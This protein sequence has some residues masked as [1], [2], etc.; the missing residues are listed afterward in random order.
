MEPTK[1]A[2]ALG[3]EKRACTVHG[4]T[5]AVR[6]R[7]KGGGGVDSGVGIGVPAD[8]AKWREPIWTQ[9]RFGSGLA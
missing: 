2:A 8:M 1:Q 4:C 9:A 6:E 5:R 7:E 3:S